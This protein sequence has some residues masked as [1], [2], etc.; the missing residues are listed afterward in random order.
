M[1]VSLKEQL[2][3]IIAID[4][5]FVRHDGTVRARVLGNT[6]NGI[7]VECLVPKRQHPNIRPMS[8]EYF[9]NNFWEG[10]K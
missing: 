10:R 4:Y 5:P 6:D 1:N 7:L 2:G 8:Q 9:D 3:N